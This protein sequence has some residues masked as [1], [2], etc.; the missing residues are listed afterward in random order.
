MAWY[1]MFKRQQTDVPP[2]AQAQ[3]VLGGP[4]FTIYGGYVDPLD[5]ELDSRLRGFNRYKTY[6]EIVANVSIVAASVRYFLNL[7]ANAEWQ[8]KPAESD[9]DGEYA[10]LAR[11]AITEDPISHWHRVVRRAAMYRFYGFSVQE[12][13]ARK[14]VDTGKIVYNDV[15]QRTQRTIEKWKIDD[16]GRVIGIIQRPPASFTDIEIPRNKTLYV[17]DDTLSDSPEGLGIFRHMADPATRLRRYQQLEGAGFESDLR[18]IPVG[19]GPFE[20]LRDKLQ[21]GQLTAAEAKAA[22]KPIRDFMNK[23]VRSERLALLLDSATYISGDDKE[24]VSAT[25]KWSVD[26]LKSSSTGLPDIAKAISR[27]NMELARILGTEQLLLG[28]GSSGSYGLSSDKTQNFF[29]LINHTLREL[30]SSVTTD[31]LY[32]LWAM[33]GYPQDKLPKI[34]TSSVQ[35]RDVKAV[36]EALRDMSVAGAVM[37]P[38]DEAIN[39]VRDLLGIAHATLYDPLE[40]MIRQGGVNPGPQNPGIAANNPP[41]KDGDGGGDVS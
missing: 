5:H 12:W 39:D 11:K 36:T 10:K 38:D 41:V 31:L 4:S 7:V 16:A 8:F 34:T 9:T 18:G 40:L 24:T 20:E 3:R 33:N 26:L 2:P 14:D 28:E 17:V 13:Q 35:H 29:L 23:H 30:A 19:K 22:E 32:P 6:A 21:S 15:M 27:L 25:P 1:D 37:A